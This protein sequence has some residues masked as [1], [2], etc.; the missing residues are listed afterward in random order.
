MTSHEILAI[1]VMINNYFHDLAVGVLFANVLLT[2]F[3]IRLIEGREGSESGLVA[4]FV[5]ISS[6]ITWVALGFVIAGG[7][8]RTATYR[9]FEWAEAAGRG[10]VAALIVKH[11]V[12]VGCT[13][14]GVALQVKIARKYRHKKAGRDG[15]AA[16]DKGE[17][18]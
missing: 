11:I 2:L 18:I 17:Q 1:V 5:R 16:M 4:D 7:I 10:Q 8:M 14:A 13:A 12:L 3:Y 15:A 6:R 9:S